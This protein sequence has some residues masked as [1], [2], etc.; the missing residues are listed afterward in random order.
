MANV[1]HHEALIEIILHLEGYLDIYDGNHH[2]II[3]MWNELW[4]KLIYL[5]YSPDT[6]SGI[7]KHMDK[8]LG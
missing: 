4:G 8:Q 1:T 6:L 3:D 7:K 2:Y 5:G